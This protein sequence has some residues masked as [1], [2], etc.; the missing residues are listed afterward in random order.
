MVTARELQVRS[1]YACFCPIVNS[2]GCSLSSV[3]LPV[4]IHGPFFCVLAVK[5]DI[6]F[7]VCSTT[8]LERKEEDLYVVITDF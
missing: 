5:V 3:I 4:T 2:I 7:D 1:I 8:E 6:D